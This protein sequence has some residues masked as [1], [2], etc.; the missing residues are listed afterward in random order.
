MAA[1]WEPDTDDQH[2]RALDRAGR[3]W[4][5]EALR[6]QWPTK[7]RFKDDTHQRAWTEALPYAV[8]ALVAGHAD[9][10]VTWVAADAYRGPDYATGAWVI[11]WEQVR[12]LEAD[13]IVA[14]YAAA[15]A[16]RAQ[17]LRARDAHLT[18]LD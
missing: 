11:C 15:Q 13:V 17:H 16:A 10:V 3:R 7:V 12:A 4:L 8:D 1:S 6:Q 5:R 2:P 9:A 14:A 18:S